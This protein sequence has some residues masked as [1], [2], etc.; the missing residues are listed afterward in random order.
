MVTYAQ[1]FSLLGQTIASTSAVSDRSGQLA[2]RYLF[3]D[4]MT[5]SPWRLKVDAASADQGNKGCSVLLLP[6]SPFFWLRQKEGSS[7]HYMLLLCQEWKNLSLMSAELGVLQNGGIQVVKGQVP[8]LWLY[9]YQR[10]LLKLLIICQAPWWDAE[11]TGN[12]LISSPVR[13]SVCMP[14][15]FFCS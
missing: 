6:S 1:H 8:V 11:Q 4:W 14:V 9:L 7:Y 3:M 12:S 15:L 5:L 2:G 13:F 10:I